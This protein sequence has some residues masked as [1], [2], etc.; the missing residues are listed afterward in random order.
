MTNAMWLAMF[1][2][3]LWLKKETGYTSVFTG[4]LQA[5]HTIGIHVF[6]GFRSYTNTYAEQ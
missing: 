5:G 4:Q 3:W 6:G 2:S 1:D